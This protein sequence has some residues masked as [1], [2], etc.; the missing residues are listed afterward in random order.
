V[1]AGVQAATRSAAARVA[2]RP[3]TLRVKF[4]PLRLMLFLLMIVTVSRIHQHYGFIAVFRPALA[5]AML[6][7]MYAFLNPKYIDVSGLLKHRQTRLVAAIGIFACIGAPFGLSLGATGKFFLDEFSKTLVFFFLLVASIRGARDLY[8]LV[9]A[10]VISSGIL[11]WMALFVFRMSTSTS[12]YTARLS[13]LYM[14]D[15]NDIGCV[16]MIGLALTLLTFQ[17]SRG[18]ARW[19]S[20]VIMLGIGAALAR[21]GS[22]GAFLA[23]GVVGAVLLVMLKTVPVAK[24]LGFVLATSL[25]L[26]IAAPPGYWQQMGTIFQPTKDYNW[27]VQDGRKQVWTRGMGYMLQYP[28]F[29][30]GLGN[31]QRAECTISDLARQHLL[32]TYLRCTPPHNSFV[33]AGAELGIPGL[34]MFTWLVVGGIVGPFRLHRRLP[35]AWRIGDAEQRFLY[36]ASLYFALAML[37]F[38]ATAFFLTFAWLDMVYIQTAL[39]VGLYVS[40]RRKLR[41]TG[42]H[43]V[44][45]RPAGPQT[46]GPAPAG[47]RGMRG[48]LA[49]AVAMRQLPRRG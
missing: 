23:L 18:K 40:V 12:S 44:G 19:A 6:T 11:V 26:V 22:R 13:H 28:I 16:L 32:N 39:T 30:L 36:N 34:I 38:A 15:A 35:K 49:P 8:V 48:G 47:R 5:L 20:A 4:D 45:A 27:T 33:Q 41:E 14:F 25:A 2:P 10:Y 21:S 24:R 43:P 31:F 1:T 9:W 17:V 29:G 42:P 3:D 37:G 7:V 46:I